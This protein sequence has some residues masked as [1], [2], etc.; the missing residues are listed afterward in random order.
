MGRAVGYIRKFSDKL[1][2]EMLREYRPDRFKTPGTNVNIGVKGDVFVLTEE[3]RH[4]LI[5]MNRR[6]LDRIN[7]FPDSGDVQ[8]QS[9][10][11]E[12]GE[13]SGPDVTP[14]EFR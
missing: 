7:A 1:Q 4:E 9:L 3:Q 14:R 5:D 12:K 11:N 6:E 10:T 13:N 2:I 8:S